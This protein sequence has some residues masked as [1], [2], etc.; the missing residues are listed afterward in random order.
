M[1]RDAAM[2]AHWLEGKNLEDESDL[3]EIAR[4][5]GLAPD[6]AVQAMDDAR[7]LGRVDALRREAIEAG[8]TGIP[9]FFIGS[10]CVVG[11]QPYEVLAMAARHAGAR[12]R[13]F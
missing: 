5:V 12:R 4:R 8:V 9:T 6:A 10:E 1:F 13:T 2:D 3:R 11:C 7:Y